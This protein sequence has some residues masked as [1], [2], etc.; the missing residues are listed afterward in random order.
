[1]LTLVTAAVTAI[2]ILRVVT[3]MIVTAHTI[4]IAIT[5]KATTPKHDT[6]TRAT[7]RGQEAHTV[8]RDPQPHNVPAVQQ[9]TIGGPEGEG[10]IRL[11]IKVREYPEEVEVPL[12]LVGETEMWKGV[13]AE[14]KD[15]FEEKII[16]SDEMQTETKEETEAVMT[17]IAMT[18]ETSMA[19]A[20][21]V[22]TMEEEI[23]GPRETG[24]AAG[25]N[26]V[27]TCVTT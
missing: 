27:V 11:V 15:V 19:I 14:T 20:A 10:M 21:T 5:T 9:R 25:M 3:T 12:A 6:P 22:V 23:V 13:F 1:M 4:V 17:V 8:H 24:G 2:A 16:V 26:T 7:R 18:L